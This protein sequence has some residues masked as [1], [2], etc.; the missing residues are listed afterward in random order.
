MANDFLKLETEA[1]KIG[2]TLNRNKCEVIGHNA[3]TRL[4]FESRG[5]DV[6]ETDLVNATL[7]RAPL[8]DSTALEVTLSDKVQELHTLS[9]RLEL[10][11]AHDA[12]YLLQHVVTTPRLMYLLRTAPCMDR[13]ELLDYDLQLRSSLSTPVEIKLRCLSG[14]EDLECVV[15]PCWHR[16]L[17]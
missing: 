17:I 5:I 10:L 7:L 8:I 13:K 6:Q 16:L 15:P 2:L 1:S 14:G 11:P 12:L 3:D 4:I 9:E